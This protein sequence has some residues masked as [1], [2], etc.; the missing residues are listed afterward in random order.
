MIASI[1]EFRPR[2]FEKQV[3]HLYYL[4]AHRPDWYADG[5]DYLIGLLAGE[6][7]DY[8]T[9]PYIK[10]TRRDIRELLIELGELK[11]FSP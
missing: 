10:W 7:T 3:Q 11:I 8:V 4:K 1:E 9:G 5:V 2:N 6:R